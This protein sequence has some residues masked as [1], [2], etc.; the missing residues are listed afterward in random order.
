M[1]YG[2][3]NKGKENK[4]DIW[5]W[6]AFFSRGGS[7][8]LKESCLCSLL[9]VNIWIIN[10]DNGFHYSDV[11]RYVKN[12]LHFSFI[13]NSGWNYYFCSYCWLFNVAKIW[14]LIGLHL[15]TVCVQL[16][17]LFHGLF[18]YSAIESLGRFLIILIS[19]IIWMIQL[20]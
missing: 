8:A 15:Y 13:S 14:K 4:M 17:K 5:G 19:H 6:Y 7:W 12:S 16:L 3:K 11:L 20:L 10:I 2:D 1:N 18:P 9:T